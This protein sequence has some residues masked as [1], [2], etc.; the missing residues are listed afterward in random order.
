M[1]STISSRLRVCSSRRITSIARAVASSSA[2]ARARPLASPA[3]GG[4]SAPTINGDESTFGIG[5]AAELSSSSSLPGIAP[6]SGGGIVVPG[7]PQPSSTASCSIRRRS[8]LL[9]A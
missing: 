3:S 6:S 9:G 4:S 2:R 1:T 7:G 8:R 5:I